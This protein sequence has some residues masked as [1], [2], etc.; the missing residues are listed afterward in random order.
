MG[1]RRAVFEVI[2][3]R[4]AKAT[5]KQEAPASSE[6]NAT[7]A[8]RAVVA[9]KTC[10]CGRR[11]AFWRCTR[12]WPASSSL[13]RVT[14]ATAM[15][16]VCGTDFSENAGQA[17][18]A[19]ASIALCLNDGLELVHVLSDPAAAGLPALGVFYAPLRVLL[20]DQA[21]KLA[22]DFSIP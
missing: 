5:P 18:R 19:A 6:S 22:S 11:S 13:V 16:I 3:G 8:A 15:T 21:T 1:A 12:R 17:A 4:N 20:A 9:R 10:A 14:G 2:G 7:A